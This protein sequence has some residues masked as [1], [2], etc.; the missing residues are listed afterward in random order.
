ML[1]SRQTRQF[2]HQRSTKLMKTVECECNQSQ[3][4]KEQQHA[5]TNTSIIGMQQD[6]AN[7]EIQESIGKS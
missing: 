6:A 5:N 4:I 2:I 1:L 7:E 3:S